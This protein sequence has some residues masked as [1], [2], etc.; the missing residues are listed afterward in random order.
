MDWLIPETLKVKLFKSDQKFLTTNSDGPPRLGKIRKCLEFFTVPTR[1]VSSHTLTLV[2]GIVFLLNLFRMH[3]RIM[4]RFI[5]FCSIIFKYH[6]TPSFRQVGRLYSISSTRGRL[7]YSRNNSDRYKLRMGWGQEG[8]VS[9][10]LAFF[11][12]FCFMSKTD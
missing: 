11:L 10:S 5:L 3:F 9:P 6:W 4:W 7:N 1:A 2:S 12:F 8:L